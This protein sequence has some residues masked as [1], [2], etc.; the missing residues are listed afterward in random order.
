M[1]VT[2]YEGIVQNGQI[3]LVDPSI[4]LPDHTRVYVVVPG[5][6]I[7]RIMSPRLVNPQDAKS[8]KMEIIE[9]DP[10]SPKS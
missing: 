7:A 1:A 9:P 8:L 3:K 2:A 5:P 10:Q 6:R 4:H